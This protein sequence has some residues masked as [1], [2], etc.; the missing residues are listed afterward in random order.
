MRMLG[1]FSRAQLFVTLWT[2]ARQASLP[3]GFSRQEYWSELPFPSPGDLPHPGIEPRSPTSAL[4]GGFFTTG[5]PGSSAG[6]ESTCNAGDLGSI[7][8]LGRYSG[9]GNGYP[10]QYSYLENPMDARAWCRL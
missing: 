9:E 3:M 4:A 7:P 6:K 10:L 1:C 8:G 2:V 5:F